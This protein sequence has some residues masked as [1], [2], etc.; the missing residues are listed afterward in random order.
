MPPFLRGIIGAR[1][2][3]AKPQD[4]SRQRIDY[5]YG[6]LRQPRGSRVEGC[7]AL[8][9][10]WKMRPARTPTHAR[11]KAGPALA[12]SR[13]AEQLSGRAC[14]RGCGPAFLGRR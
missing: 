6:R 1:R 5:C 7:E 13:L 9:T 8:R 12:R 2:R 11:V 10:R 3:A 14:R 4:G